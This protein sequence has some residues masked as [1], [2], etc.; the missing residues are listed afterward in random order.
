[1][2]LADSVRGLINCVYMF[3]VAGWVIQCSLLLVD[4][5]VRCCWLVDSV[6]VV[7]GWL[8]SVFVVAG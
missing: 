5:S 4:V 8:M 7:A 6:F 1:M 3:V 2:L